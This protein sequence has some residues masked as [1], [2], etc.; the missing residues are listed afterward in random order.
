MFRGGHTVDLGDQQRQPSVLAAGEAGERP[1]ERPRDGG[2][3]R[4][5]PSGRKT[6]SWRAPRLM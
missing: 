4:L 2:A 3:R 6:R 1:A 5:V